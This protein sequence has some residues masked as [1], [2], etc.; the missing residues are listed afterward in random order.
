MARA[1]TA[2]AVMDRADAEPA[3]VDDATA[4]PA[5]VPVMAPATPRPDRPVPGRWWLWGDPDPWP[6]RVGGFWT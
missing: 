3:P 6:E 1:R 4:E 2:V 5:S